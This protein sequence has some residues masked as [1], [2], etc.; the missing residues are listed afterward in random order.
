MQNYN[1][2]QFANGP[3]GDESV[4]DALYNIQETYNVDPIFAAAVTITESSAGTANTTLIQ[5]AHNW[6]SIKGSGFSYNGSQWNYY[7]SFADA[8]EGSNGFGN[9]MANSGYYFA[10]GN[11]HISE[12][13]P[14]YCDWDWSVKTAKY[15]QQLL[16]CIGEGD[17][18]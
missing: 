16:E 18:D 7:S 14:T 3:W 17:E 4:V 1:G 12:I 15:M 8:L 13:G 6:V 10:A 11:I 9:L 5:Q 2:G